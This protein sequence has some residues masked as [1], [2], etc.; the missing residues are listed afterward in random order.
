MNDI[1]DLRIFVVSSR[2][3]VAERNALASMRGCSKRRQNTF[4]GCVS[5][6]S[7]GVVQY[8]GIHDKCPYGIWSFAMKRHFG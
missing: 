4:V 7:A 2:E 5:P 8:D 1:K 6:G 3:M